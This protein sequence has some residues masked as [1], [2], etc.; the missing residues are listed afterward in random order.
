MLDGWLNEGMSSVGSWLIFGIILLPVYGMFLGWFLG[1]PRNLRLA[2]MGTSYLV[3]MTTVLWGG[4]AAFVALLG[5]V[6]F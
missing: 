6:F 4:L 5:Y 1:K 2:L 3:G